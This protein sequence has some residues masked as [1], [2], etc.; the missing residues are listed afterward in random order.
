[1]VPEVQAGQAGVGLL[2]LR[3]LGKITSK[4]LLIALSLL[5]CREDSKKQMQHMSTASSK[6]TN[7]P[8]G[9]PVALESASL[10]RTSRLQRLFDLL[11]GQR[12]DLWPCWLLSTLQPS[13]GPSRESFRWKNWAV[14]VDLSFEPTSTLNSVR[15]APSATVMKT[16]TI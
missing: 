7:K 9:F 3:G 1:M 14:R 5:S 2:L 12:L 10:L 8:L 16:S 13:I 15:S 6:T 4:W 11:Q